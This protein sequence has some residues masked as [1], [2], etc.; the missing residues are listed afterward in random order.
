MK[1]EAK[2]IFC[3]LSFSFIIKNSECFVFF[4]VKSNYTLKPVRQKAVTADLLL[5]TL[6]PEHGQSFFTI[7]LS[8][9]TY[10]V[11]D[12]HPSALHLLLDHSQTFPYHRQ[13]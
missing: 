4:V 3:H 12:T 11:C 1:N 13:W 2:V 8:V 5:L 10:K 6:Y 9:E 7:K